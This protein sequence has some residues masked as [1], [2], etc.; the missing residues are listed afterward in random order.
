MTLN[1]SQLT[2]LKNEILT[3]P[4]KVGYS[5]Y[6]GISNVALAG[7]LNATT[8][9]GAA[10]IQLSTI[11][12]GSL[13]LQIVPWL[14]QLSTSQTVSGTAIPAATVTKWQQRFQ[15]LQAA[16]PTIAV[17]S[18][19]PMMDNGIS[20]GIATAAQVSSITTKIGSRAEVLFGSGTV[21][22]WQDVQDA[23]GS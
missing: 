20:D 23:L 4:L 18:L 2:T 10:I 3:D 8:G 9:P 19:L 11:T 6:V 17:S 14:D 21:I 7:M 22:L 16:D 13:L 1:T 15:A 12:K 5:S